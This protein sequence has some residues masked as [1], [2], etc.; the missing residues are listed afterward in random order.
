[1]SLNSVLQTLTTRIATEC[2]ALRTEINAGK[3]PTGT[4]AP[5]GGLKAPSGYLLCDGSSVSRTTYAA[6]FSALT[7]S[8]TVSATNG[9]ATVTGISAGDWALLKVG[10]EVQVGT[11]RTTILAKPSSGTITLASSYTGATG[12]PTLIVLPW[13]SADTTTFYLPQLQDVL[14]IGVGSSKA[15]AD[16]GG[17]T[18]KILTVGNLPAHH[19]NVSGLTIPTRE[20]D[21]LTPKPNSTA[22]AYTN[23]NSRLAT[24]GG[25]SGTSADRAWITGPTDDTGSGDPLNVENPYVAVNYIIKT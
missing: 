3:V 9:S 13:E 14:P 16:A 12:S 6:L 20:G 24:A 5:F 18:S 8:T 11:M 4:I 23:S 19:H 21:N 17:S 1:M 22:S 2:K 15:L 25:T 7:L 10:W